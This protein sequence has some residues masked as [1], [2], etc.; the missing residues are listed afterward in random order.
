M[1]VR[2]FRLTTGE[3]VIAEVVTTVGAIVV[4]KAIVIMVVQDDAGKQQIAM[5]DLALFGKKND[6]VTLHGVVTEYEPNQEIV[7]M[8]T[9]KTSGLVLAS[10]VPDWN[11]RIGDF[12]K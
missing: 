10:S 8:W 5:V 1:N 11:S 2:V 12:G 9:R 3:D 7:N 4:K 6:E